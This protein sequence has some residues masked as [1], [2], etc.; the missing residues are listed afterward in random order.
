MLG[1]LIAILTFSRRTDSITDPARVIDGDTIVV[2]G[3]RLHGIDVPELYR[4]R[5]RQRAAAEGWKGVRLGTT[6]R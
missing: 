5:E 2:V 3:H 4:R 1:R 6:L